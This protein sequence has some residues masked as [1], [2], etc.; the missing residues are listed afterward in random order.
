[1]YPVWFKLAWIDVP[2][3]TA[4]MVLALGA[5]FALTWVA[6][7]RADLPPTDVLDVA[8]VAVL[9]G[10]IGARAGYV[11]MNWDYYHSHTNEIVQVWQGGLMWHSGWA[12][13]VIGAAVASAWRKLDLRAVLSALTPGLMAGAAL[14]WIGCYLAGAAYGREVFPGDRWWFLAA[15]L[16]DM[17]G[18]RNPR[19]ATQMLGAGWAVVCFG[20]SNIAPPKEGDWRMANSRFAASGIRFAVAMLFYS[21]GMFVLGFTRG[22]AVPMLGAW[23]LDQVMDV[24][25]VVAGILYVLSSLVIQIAAVKP[26]ITFPRVPPGRS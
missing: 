6:A 20:I 7:R 11:A 15:D 2:S 21:A 19:F 13:G 26:E 23:R 9:V 22:D 3:F 4:L 14:G 25:I 10:V 8:L 16:P 12:G 18:L 5:G 24:G 1:M 17:Y